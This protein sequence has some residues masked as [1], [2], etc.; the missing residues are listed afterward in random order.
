MILPGDEGGEAE[1]A[2][3]R[4]GRQGPPPRPVRHPQASSFARRGDPG[5]EE[6]Q[7]RG[8]GW[9]LGHGKYCEAGRTY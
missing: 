8:L 7:P 2:E 6:W 1:E 4:E 3:G 9:G 5:P